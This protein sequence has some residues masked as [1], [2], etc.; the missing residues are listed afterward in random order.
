[1]KQ[2]NEPQVIIADQILINRVNRGDDKAFGLLVAKYQHRIEPVVARYVSDPDEMLDVVQ[3]VF[4]KAYRGLSDFR[5]D[6]Q[7]FTWLFVIATNTAKTFLQ[8]KGRRPPDQD[9][10][11]A[12]ADMIAVEGLE[13]LAS[14][15]HIMLRDELER[16]VF[17]AIQNLPHEMQDAIVLREI[18]GMSYEDIANQMHVPIGTVRSRISRARE[19]IDQSVKP[20][21]VE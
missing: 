9:I 4:I 6:S 19:L 1:M 21:L 20:L 10:D 15:E 12:D 3:E 5:G 16:T 14:P 18:E 13:E 8:A 17:K 7:F 2:H 11:A